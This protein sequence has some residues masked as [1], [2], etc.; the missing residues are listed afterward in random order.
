MVLF[1]NQLY[2]GK[3]VLITGCAWGS[4]GAAVALQVCQLGAAGLAICGRREEPLKDAALRLENQ[5]KT[6]VFY[7]SCDIRDPD[8]VESFVA[9]V[10]A[11][12]GRI[13]VLFNN[14]GG[15]FPVMA[16]NL[17]SKGFNA[18][19][20]NNLL[21][22]WNMTSSVARLAFIPQFEKLTEAEKKGAN[23]DDPTQSV[24]CC[25]PGMVH[26]GSARAGVDNMTKTLAVEW[27]KYQIK[28][29]AVAPGTIVS[30]GTQRYPKEMLDKSRRVAPLQRLGTC[31][32][33]ANICTFLGS[34]E[35]AGFI[36]GQ[37]FYMEARVWQETS[38]NFN[39]PSYKTEACV[40]VCVCGLNGPTE[41]DRSDNPRLFFRSGGKQHHKMC[42]PKLFAAIFFALAGICVAGAIIGCVVLKKEIDSISRYDLN[43]TLAI[44]DYILDA[45]STTSNLTVTL[46]N[47]GNNNNIVNAR[48]DSPR[49]S[50]LRKF[51]YVDMCFSGRVFDRDNSSIKI[52][53]TV[54]KPYNGTIIQKITQQYV[55]NYV[56]NTTNPCVQIATCYSATTYFG[57]QESNTT[58]PSSFTVATNT[59]ESTSIKG[60]I[61]N[62]CNVGILYTYPGIAIIAFACVAGAIIFLSFALACVLI[63]FIRMVMLGLL[64]VLLIGAAIAFAVLYHKI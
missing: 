28:V 1:K 55:D 7:Q 22:T 43:G 20:R 57:F 23:E 50:D 36:T 14:A 26:T 51:I 41:C 31:E 25:F 13:D 58:A 46:R 9:A 2:S 40:C 10:V 61:K 54:T 3:V 62:V 11:K 64:A 48:Y 17:N 47:N 39:R 21:G 56:V 15:Q 24:P 32:E 8:A 12:F 53:T 18:V 35:A 33:V 30:T 6:P 27:A 60:N 29:N 38:L 19:I 59:T 49:N 63:G 4:I 45:N 42:M 37:T 34:D 16:E 52:F 5:S 44:G